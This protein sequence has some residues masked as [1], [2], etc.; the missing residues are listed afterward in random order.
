MKFNAPMMAGIGLI[1]GACLLGLSPTAFAA[2]T[3]MI[4]GQN[5]A[6][7]TGTM[8]NGQ[9]TPA[10]AT[11]NAQPAFQSNFPVLQLQEALD[12]HGADL[13]VDGVFG[14]RTDSALKHYQRDHG[15]LASGEL[16]HATRASLGLLG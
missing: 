2:Q 12:A 1:G 15:L 5:T 10:P 14:P 11:Q 7:A 8:N 9:M 6:S 16:D 4:Q 13:T 3:G